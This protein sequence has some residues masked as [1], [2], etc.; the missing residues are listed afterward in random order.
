[1]PIELSVRELIALNVVGWLMVQLVNAWA[2]TKI[3]AAWF[4]PGPARLWEAGGM[5]YERAFIIKRWKDLLPD[6]ASWF[7]GGFPKARLHGKNSAYLARFVRE[8]RRGELCHWAAIACAPLFFLWNPWWGDLIIVAVA[9]GANLPCIVV[10]RYN[11]LRLARVLAARTPR[12][13]PANTN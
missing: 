4:T 11:R 7:T 5:L 12:S 6:G 8:T 13:M 3:P 1:M 9:L 10:Q 2:F